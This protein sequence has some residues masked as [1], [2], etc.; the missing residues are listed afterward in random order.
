MIE[1]ANKL[2]KIEFIECQRFTE[3]N[4]PQEII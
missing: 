3:N 4:Y 2:T 1:S